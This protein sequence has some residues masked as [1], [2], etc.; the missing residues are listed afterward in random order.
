MRSKEEMKKFC[1]FYQLGTCKFATDLECSKKH[2]FLKKHEI[3]FLKGLEEK[4][5]K[6]KGERGEGKGKE[7]SKG[8][9]ASSRSAN[10][11]TTAKGLDWITL[12]RKKLPFCCTAFKNDGVC[13]YEKE[14]G[15]TCS[16]KHYN[17][18]EYDALCVKLAN[19][20]A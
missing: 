17:P 1:R 8:A 14:T 16:F 19:G 11:Q 2:Q 6:K 9:R 18:A 13:K 20:T 12:N 10:M 4:R 15:K 5:T 7:T 3:E